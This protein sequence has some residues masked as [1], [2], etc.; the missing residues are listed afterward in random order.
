VQFSATQKKDKQ[1]LQEKE[2]ARNE[3][4]D[5]VAKLKALRQAKEIVDKEIAD[6]VEAEK[7]AKAAAKK[8]KKKA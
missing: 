8:K 6:A 5:G 3:R 1:F 2:W 7:A 4:A